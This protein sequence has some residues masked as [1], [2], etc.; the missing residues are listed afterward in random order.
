MYVG[1]LPVYG[2]VSPHSVHGAVPTLSPQMA[3]GRTPSPLEYE[4]PAGPYS[5]SAAFQGNLAGSA[6]V[7]QMAPTA[8]QST[9]VFRNLQAGGTCSYGSTSP[10]P[11][12]QE[13]VR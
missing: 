9:N 11:Y 3:V 13:M 6:R 1:S 5:P 2:S 4:A 10:M 12:Q 7:G 8:A